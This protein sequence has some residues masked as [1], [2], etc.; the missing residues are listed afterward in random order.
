MWE[1]GTCNDD[2][3]SNHMCTT[4]YRLH[5]GPNSC[6]CREAHCSCTTQSPPQSS[7]GSAHNNA[8]LLARMNGAR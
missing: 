7:A 8:L 2:G 3:Y 4:P 1:L 6:N 5:P